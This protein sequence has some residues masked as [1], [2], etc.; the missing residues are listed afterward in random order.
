MIYY[1]SKKKIPR[2]AADEAAAV[3]QN[4]KE[5]VMSERNRRFHIGLRTVKTVAAVII[6]MV[7]VDAYG[8]TTSKLIFAMLGAMAAVQ[9]TFKE[10]A[11]SCLSQ[12]VGVLFGALMGVLLLLLPVSHLVI[13][14][15]GIVLV[16]TLYN[17]LGIRFSPSL[18][19]FMIV[20]LCTSPG[21]QPLSYA[22]G[23]VWDTAIG[24]AI[25]MLINTLIFP[26]DNR[27]Q[28]RVTMESLDRE[29][30]LFLEDMFDGDDDLPDVEA[31]AG[32]IDDIERQ[33]NIFA[34]QKLFMRPGRYRAQLEAFREYET[35]ARRLISHMEVLCHLERPGEI[36]PENLNRLDACGARVKNRADCADMEEYSDVINY[37][38]TH[39]L[40][41]REQLRGAVSEPPRRRWG[42]KG[43]TN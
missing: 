29:L 7:V 32:K 19:C 23:R 25:G 36:T 12:I 8:A 20:M 18:P 31:M 26:Y 1:I 14:G 21:V 10:S 38:I 22:L 6:A 33:L 28:I 30:I 39:I 17:A 34:N 24:M 11:E 2:A 41:L 3:Y 42:K 37:H 27:R 16:I 15:I 13:T 43:A 35:N 40:D 5:R 9:P 4:R